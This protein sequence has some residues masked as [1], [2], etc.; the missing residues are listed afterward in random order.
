[1]CP[2]PV[3][4]VFVGAG[5]GHGPTQ[6]LLPAPRASPSANKS[7]FETNNK[8]QGIHSASSPCGASTPASVFPRFEA[9]PF[10]TCKLGSRSS[11]SP[12]PTSPPRCLLGLSTAPLQPS[13]QTDKQLFIR[14]ENGEQQS[15]QVGDNSSAKGLGEQEVF[16]LQPPVVPWAVCGQCQL[17]EQTNPEFPSSPGSS[18][19]GAVLAAQ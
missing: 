11:A 4:G 18:G 6:S 15:K 3:Q 9:N 1:M 10:K 17:S 14:W 19:L 5:N 8:I 12:Q 2:H 13:T 7:Q 16:E